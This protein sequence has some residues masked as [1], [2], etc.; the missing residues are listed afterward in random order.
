MLPAVP[1]PPESTTGHAVPSRQQA[2]SHD[3]IR[4]NA[5]ISS[6][7]AEVDELKAERKALLAKMSHA[8]EEDGGRLAKLDTEVAQL[9]TDRQLL[10][11]RLGTAEQLLAEAR[12]AVDQKEGHLQGLQV[13][14]AICPFSCFSSC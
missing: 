9:K 11:S 10:I 6:L 7:N 2:S 4:H 5:K 8:G 13:S 12:R 1:L 3:S 14:A